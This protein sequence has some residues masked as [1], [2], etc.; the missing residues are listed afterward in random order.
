MMG[1]V[2]EPLSMQRYFSETVDY[3]RRQE[4]RSVMADFGT[5]VCVYLAADGNRCAVGY[6]IPDDVEL[7]A[8]NASLYYVVKFHPELCGVAWPDDPQGVDLAIELQ[9][10][11]DRPPFR[12]QTGGGLS[13]V[14]EIF[15]RWIAD[16]FG[17]T[18]TGPS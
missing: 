11:H 8:Q 14:G 5:D 3:L 13:D 1:A 9:K 10:L 15:A 6:W 17:L 4:H 2:V 7:A 16:K 12:G 18:Y